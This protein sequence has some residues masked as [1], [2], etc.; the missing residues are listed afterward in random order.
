M[1]KISTCLVWMMMMTLSHQKRSVI[2]KWMPQTRRRW[3]YNIAEIYLFQ[4]FNHASN[5]NAY[6]MCWNIQLLYYLSTLIQNSNRP[7]NYVCDR[8]SQV[9]RPTYSCPCPSDLGQ[10]CRCTWLLDKFSIWILYL[11][12]ERFTRHADI[13]TH[14]RYKYAEAVTTTY[15]I[16][17]YGKSIIITDQ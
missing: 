15:F 4:Y 17:K 1:L 12:Q 6:L 2:S 11:D 7:R 3:V 8:T 5:H 9:I 14:R 13:T 16:L 10:P